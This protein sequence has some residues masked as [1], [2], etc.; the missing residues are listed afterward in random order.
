MGGLWAVCRK[1][2]HIAF[3]FDK[4]VSSEGMEFCYARQAFRHDFHYFKL[5]GKE[6]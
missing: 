3:F 4:L 6:G 2:L 5:L 1:L